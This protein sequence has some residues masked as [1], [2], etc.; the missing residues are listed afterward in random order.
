MPAPTTVTPLPVLGPSASH[1]DFFVGFSLPWRS[2]GLIRRHRTLRLL[3]LAMAAVTALLLLVLAGLLFSWT[4][5]LFARLVPRPESA[6]LLPLWWLGVAAVGL[7]AFVLG[8]LTLPPL[9]LS[10][11]QDPLGEATEALHGG[12]TPPF[13]VKDL[14]V[15]T[16][17]G[18]RHTL[19]RLGLTLLGVLLLLPLNFVP[20]LGSVVYGTLA[21]LWGMFALAAEHVGGPIARHRYPARTVFRLARER[22]ALFLGLGAAVWLVLIIPVV[23]AFFLP[24]AVIA[25]AEAFVSL[26]RAGALPRKPGHGAPG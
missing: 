22:T 26:E 18:L 2:V 4:D 23:N 13:S 11:L 8:A 17:I 10:P 5:D 19:V 20:G 12:T 21:T 15:G 9:A 14:F 16:W 24:L 3:S 25:G 1:R 7:L 6:W